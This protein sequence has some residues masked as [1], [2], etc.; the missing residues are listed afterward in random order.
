[1]IP[2]C[3]SCGQP[4]T[5][6]LAGVIACAGSGRHVD[7]GSSYACVDRRC[8]ERRDETALARAIARGVIAP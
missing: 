4:M 3:P 8:Q 2:V 7:V 5:D 1:M 6:I